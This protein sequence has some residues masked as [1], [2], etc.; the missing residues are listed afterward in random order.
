MGKH[1]FDAFPG[2]AHPGARL[3]VGAGRLLFVPI[4]EEM[5]EI[6][7]FARFGL[8]TA[9]GHGGTDQANAALLAAG[10]LFGINVASIHEVFSRLEMSVVQ[11]G[12]NGADRFSVRDRGDCG[13][14]LNNQVG[15]GGIFWPGTGFRQVDFVP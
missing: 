11:G 12:L 6:E 14:D 8:P 10:K 9:V 7:A 13:V 1:D 4:D 15:G 2:L 5:G 3:P